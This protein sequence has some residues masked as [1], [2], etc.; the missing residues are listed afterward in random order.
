MKFIKYI[1]AIILVLCAILAVLLFEKSPKKATGTTNDIY[2]FSTE[3]Y[4]NLL[5]DTVEIQSKD[6]DKLTFYYKDKEG[7]KI[8]DISSLRSLLEGRNKKLIFGTNGG[9]FSTTSEPLGLYIEN[10]RTLFN[11]NT[12]SG[13][14]NFY[15]Q[16]NGVFLIKRDGAEIVVTERYG[17]SSST[18]YTIQSGP[19][20]VIDGK[21]NTS[22]DENS[23]SKY[24]R[25]G[26]GIGKEG[27]VFF[28]I[29][30]EPVTFYEFASFFKDAVGCGNAL[31][32]DGAISE[33]YV[34]EYRKKTEQKF[35]VIIGIEE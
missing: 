22:F 31:Y 5:F 25:N 21:I 1:F 17:D 34:P 12:S 9:I 10:G 7:K 6:I 29:S 16:P 24:I 35:G 8:T 3:E 15:L 33:M 13:E 11:V 14:G 19:L 18:A 30:N 23:Q 2:R 20:L 32:L 27:N 4:H 26:V 28:A